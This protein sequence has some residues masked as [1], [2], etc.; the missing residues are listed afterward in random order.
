[1]LSLCQF[2][3]FGKSLL[4][5]LTRSRYEWCSNFSKTSKH[6]KVPFAEDI[7]TIL[8]MYLNQTQKYRFSAALSI[9]M[10]ISSL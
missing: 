1:M 10:K 3:Y 4:I 8:N 9:G 6:K 5:I 7:A 2:V